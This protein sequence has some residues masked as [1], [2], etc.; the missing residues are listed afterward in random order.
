MHTIKEVILGCHAIITQEVFYDEINLE[1][2]NVFATLMSISVYS[3]AN[4]GECPSECSKYNG[5]EEVCPTIECSNSG[6]NVY[7]EHNGSTKECIPSGNGG[8]SCG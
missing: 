6:I 4:C 8:P 3:Y 2:Y 1:K 7:C 5:N